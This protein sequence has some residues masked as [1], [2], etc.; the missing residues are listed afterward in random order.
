M[1]Y[2]RPRLCFVPTRNFRVKNSVSTILQE[3]RRM[4]EEYEFKKAARK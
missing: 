3:T 1:N 4:R 2:M